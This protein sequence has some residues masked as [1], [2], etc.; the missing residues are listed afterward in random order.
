MDAKTYRCHPSHY[1]RV[2]EQ[3]GGHAQVVSCSVFEVFYLLL[4]ILQLLRFLLLFPFLGGKGVLCDRHFDINDA[5]RMF[6]IH[7]VVEKYEGTLC[8]ESLMS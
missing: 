1:I 6:F 5:G 2:E 7:N 3:L 4:G 8:K